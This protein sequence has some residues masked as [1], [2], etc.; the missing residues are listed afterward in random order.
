M[1]DITAI[2]WK[3]L[4]E[5]EEAATESAVKNANPNIAIDLAICLEM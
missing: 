5:E 1:V 4:Q 2:D 3:R